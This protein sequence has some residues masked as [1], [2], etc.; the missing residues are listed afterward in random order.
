MGISQVA[1]AGVL[2]EVTWLEVTLV[3]CPVRKYVMR[4]RNR[5]L[6]NILPSGAFSPE[7]TSGS[8]VTGRDPVRK[9]P[10]PEVCSVHPRIF[11]RVVFLTRV[12]VQFWSEV[13][14]GW[15]HRKSPVRKYVQDFVLNQF[16]QDFTHWRLVHQQNVILGQSLMMF[17]LHGI[18]LSKKSR[19]PMTIFSI[20]I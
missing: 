19:I 1:F 8:H 15:R 13:T 17:T 10:W 11:P 14:S 9:R 4:M 18:G 2:P 16:V 12:V 7:V 20:D 6:L 3:T 5:K